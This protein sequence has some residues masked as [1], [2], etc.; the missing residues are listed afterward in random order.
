MASVVGHVHVGRATAVGN[1]QPGAVASTGR[2]GRKILGN[3]VG[4]NTLPGGAIMA[5]V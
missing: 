5:L 3:V 1:P 4:S 2:A